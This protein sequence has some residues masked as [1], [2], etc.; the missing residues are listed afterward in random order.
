MSIEL[1]SFLPHYICEA[2]CWCILY[3]P[4]YFTSSLSFPILRQTHYPDTAC[5]LGAAR[6]TEPDR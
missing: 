5:I 2:R 3:L 1:R 4:C 6:E